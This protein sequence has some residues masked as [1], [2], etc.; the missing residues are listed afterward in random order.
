MLQ[1]LPVELPKRAFSIWILSGQH[2]IVRGPVEVARLPL[3]ASLF[4]L[5]Q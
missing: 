5:L 4:A 3:L 2:L 1:I